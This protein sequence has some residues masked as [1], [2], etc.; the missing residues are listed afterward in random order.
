M[1]TYCYKCKKYTTIIIKIM[2]VV[3]YSAEEYDG[4]DDLIWS[5]VENF[6]I[7]QIVYVCE[8]SG[9]K[10]KNKKNYKEKK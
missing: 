8:N 2:V 7:I 1:K 5:D 9:N 4:S 3:E 10:T 6:E